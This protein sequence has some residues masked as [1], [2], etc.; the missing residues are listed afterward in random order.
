M[1]TRVLLFI[2]SAGLLVVSCKGKDKEKDMNTTTNAD[3]MSTA[4]TLPAEH[5][6][7]QPPLLK[8]KLRM[9]QKIFPTYRQQS[10]MVK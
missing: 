7:L 10:T 8:L 4:D 3:T 9:Q 6:L 2:F 5:R 1:K